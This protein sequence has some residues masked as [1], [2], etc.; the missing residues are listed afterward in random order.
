MYNIFVRGYFIFGLILFTITLGSPGIASDKF[1]ARIISEEM[2]FEIYGNGTGTYSVQSK[3]EILKSGGSLYGLITLPESKFFKIKKFEGWLFNAA[4]D[5]IVSLTKKDNF[6]V[7]GFAEYAFYADDCHRVYSLESNNPPYLI[8]YSYELEIKSLYFWPEWTPQKN[9][10][11]AYSKYTLITPQQTTFA[12]KAK[13]NIPLPTVSFKD[14]KQIIVYEL[15]NIEPLDEESFIYDLDGKLTGVC[16]VAD[17][18]KLGKY[19]FNGGSWSSFGYDCFEMMK[20]C[21]KLNDEQKRVIENIRDE[22]QSEIQI[23]RALHEYITDK[24]RYV[25]IEINIGGWKP[26]SS[27]ETFERGYGDC[28]DLSVLYVSMLN[29]VGIESRPA[30]VLTKD[31]GLVDS[32][33]PNLSFN[34]FIYFSIIEGDTVWSDPTCPFCD[35]GDLPWQDE[36][37]MVL[38][39]DSLGGGLVKTSN[40]TSDDN[41]C[42]RNV[43]IDIV[44]AKMVRVKYNIRGLG[45]VKQMLQSFLNYS[46]LEMAGT[47]LKESDIG[48]TRKVKYDSIKV[49][50][51]DDPVIFVEGKVKNAIQSLDGKKY[52]SIDYFSFLRLSEKINLSERLYALDLKYPISFIDSIFINIPA[53]WEIDKLPDIVDYVN[54]FGAI[55]IDYH[56]NGRQLIVSCNRRSHHYYISEEFISA[57]RN[58]LS[59]IERL[60]KSHIV[61]ELK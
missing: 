26:T 41:I 37:I 44:S 31:F 8:E 46:D 50:E 60:K 47:F 20:Q 42:F 3:I 21:F 49:I 43:E 55:H 18:Y 9:I 22:N 24:T 51:E 54:E 36:D 7:C 5:T 53:Q 28:K 13:E 15:D 38:A 32:L 16:F 39:L 30:L 4:G 1:D 2:V 14:D 10:P 61:F 59:E 17:K 40:S 33:F 52:L 45:N 56:L 19:D 57:F 11:V 29:H 6:K 58:Y 23:A 35:V 27:E 25:A 12:T 34:H 48:L